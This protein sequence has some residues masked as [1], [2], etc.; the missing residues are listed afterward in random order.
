ME[1]KESTEP[2][3]H[4]DSIFICL[5]KL[6]HWYGDRLTPVFRRLWKKTAAL[7]ATEF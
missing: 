6:V 7:I 3:E 5:M 1:N 4:A 2:N